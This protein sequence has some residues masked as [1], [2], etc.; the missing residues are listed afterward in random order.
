MR[1]VKALQIVMT[2]VIGLVLLSPAT[3]QSVNEEELDFRFWRDL[4]AGTAISAALLDFHKPSGKIKL[5]KKGGKT[6][7]H[8][9]KNFHE[10]D[11]TYVNE[12]QA[13]KEEMAA[14]EAAKIKAA[15]GPEKVATEIS[16][17]IEMRV[18]TS[19]EK[20]KTERE[21]SFK[22][23]PVNHQ[24]LVQVATKRGAPQINKGQLFVTAFVGHETEH[25]QLK[26][27]NSEPRPEHSD[28]KVFEEKQK[29]VAVER[30]SPGKVS[31]FK[32]ELN[33]LSKKGEHAYKKGNKNREVDWE[34]EQ[35]LIG[36][37]A[38][39]MIDGKLASEIRFPEDLEKRVARYD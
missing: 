33:T 15:Q 20:G 37:H 19:E 17:A 25:A 4:E 3:G 24:I 10:E 2:G 13:F 8:D 32:F 14:K 35:K 6:E 7:V 1:I 30:F 11:Q 26:G 5:Y 27:K 36:V 21:G 23:Y 16:K 28:E 22:S 34:H 9:L 31:D 39:I 29:A 12:W 38:R 18:S